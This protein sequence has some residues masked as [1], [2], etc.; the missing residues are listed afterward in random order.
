MT[1]RTSLLFDVVFD[2]FDDFEFHQWSDLPVEIKL[3]I[4]KY[5]TFPTLRYFMFLSKECY[6]LVCKVKPTID[7]Y[8]GDVAYLTST[9]QQTLG[10]YRDGVELHIYW[11]K[12]ESGPKS[13]HDYAL[14]F[15]KDDK[16][17]CFVQRMIKKKRKYLE[18][19]GTNYSS[20][21]LTAAIKS[22]FGLSD[23]LD[24][25]GLTVAMYSPNSRLEAVLAEQP[26]SQKIARKEF[27][28]DFE[29]EPSITSQFLRF[30]K[31]GCGITLLKDTSAE[32]IHEP[33]LFDHKIFRCAHKIKLH[34]WKVGMTDDQLV[35]LAADNIYITA[36]HITSRAINKLV[37]EWLE[38]KRLINA[39]ELEEV[40]INK[41]LI[42]QNLDPTAIM[43]FK[44]FLK[45]TSYDGIRIGVEL[46]APVIRGPQGF[47]MV[48]TDANHC[49]LTDPYFDN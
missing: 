18:L 21:I 12:P 3:H 19:P 42:L 35:Q 47:L 25:R 49:L 24:I 5:L 15:V 41:T 11:R 17:G 7:L 1:E 23:V 37:R 46:T 44:D 38:G 14:L 36:P 26:S 29:G 28:L 2:V 22:V 13:A 27:L 6:D 8:L 31:P 43:Q 4:L 34:G 40:Q 30:L 39:I 33:D 16:E 45:V 20:D 9:K 10:K 32:V 48:L